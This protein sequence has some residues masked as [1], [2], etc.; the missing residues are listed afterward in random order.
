[1]SSVLGG[2][3]NAMNPP[4]NLNDPTVTNQDA[5][6]QNAQANPE[7]VE[8]LQNLMGGK[9]K[10]DK[11]EE[12]VTGGK[13]KHTDTLQETDKDLEHA[14]KIGKLS[15]H[16]YASSASG[17]RYNNEASNP[18]DSLPVPGSHEDMPSGKAGTGNPWFAGNVYVAYQ[19]A[20]AEALKI[21]QHLKVIEMKNEIA[22]M[23]MINDLAKE[24]ADAVMSSA[25]AEAM[26][27]F[28]Q[29]VTGAIMIGVNCGMLMKMH[30]ANAT[31]EKKY[32]EG[33]TA[34]QEAVTKR[35]TELDDSLSLAGN[36][37]TGK[38]KQDFDSKMGELKDVNKQI[39][40]KKAQLQTME[41]RAELRSLDSKSYEKDLR[42]NYDLTQAEVKENRVKMAEK[43]KAQQKDIDTYKNEQSEKYAK[44]DPADPADPEY[45]NFRK[46]EAAHQANSD[47]INTYNQNK[48]QVAKTPEE[49]AKQDE[50]LEAAKNDLQGLQE[51][52]NGKRDELAKIAGG[53]DNPD[54]D[55]KKS[56]LAAQK[57]HNDAVTELK[58]YQAGKF[59]HI[60]RS[61]QEIMM[62]AT[63]TQQ[64]ASSFKETFDSTVKGV[65]TLEKGH[66]DALLKRIDGWQTIANKAMNSSSD[67]FKNASDQIDKLLSTLQNLTS[68]LMRAFTL[69][70]QQG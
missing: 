35:Q 67:S 20:F 48:A 1:M 42:D 14:S 47:E 5:I 53:S 6:D 55:S 4:P 25:K 23:I 40:D 70:K 12:A 52:A 34:R 38:S 39:D 44:Q 58:T 64:L 10:K 54:M 31:A 22:S 49:A 43:A 63:I 2:G 32:Q 46:S 50:E 8:E 61:R 19:T 45:V 41:K 24:A 18:G 9:V 66:Y 68:S 37:L 59:E 27:H 36:K 65:S 26:A 57:N 11:E 51:S 30:R 60:S 29:A 13:R 28:T 15:D 62:M 3:G 21:M 17:K 33:V 69:A 16:T 7:L 56:V